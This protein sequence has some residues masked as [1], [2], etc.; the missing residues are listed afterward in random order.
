MVVVAIVLTLAVW[1]VPALA[2]QVRNRAM[3]NVGLQVQQ[4]LRQVQQAALTTR[5]P[6]SVSFSFNTSTR[7]YSYTFTYRGTSRTRPLHQDIVLSPP[8]WLTTPLWFDEFGRPSSKDG[9]GNLLKL[10]TDAAIVF[11]NKA[12]DKQITV[13]V[14]HVLGRSSLT[15]TIR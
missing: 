2:F 15:W 7:T 4:D 12:G 14:G 9:G 10:T 11:T 5:V 3:Y 13:N 1:G 6:R 8:S